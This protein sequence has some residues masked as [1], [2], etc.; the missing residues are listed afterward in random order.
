MNKNLI[1]I[2]TRNPELGKVKTRLAATIG[3][4][5]ALEIYEILL[6]HTND[7]VK[8]IQVAR[9]VYYS[10]EINRND[11]W[12]NNL[13]QK[14]EQFGQDLG[15]RMK[16]AFANAFEDGYENVV[17][18]GTD[19]YD[20]EVADLNMAFE[21]LEKY[22]IVIG[23][24]E[25]GGYYLLGLK[26]IPKGIFLNKFWGSNSVLRDTVD[27]IE[28]LNYHLLKTKNDIDTIYDI[29]KIPEFQKYI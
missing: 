29:K 28:G 23:P 7:I 24:A 15:A 17:I 14:H 2:F 1:L 10:E 16:N 5:N 27:D 21:K 8:K 25:D 22:D 4:K 11:I 9:K 3:N 26:F 12:D 18:I 6:N 20:L 13:Y 19:L